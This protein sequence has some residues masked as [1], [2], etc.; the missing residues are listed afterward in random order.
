M[1]DKSFINLLTEENLSKINIDPRLVDSF[2]RVMKNHIIN[3][4]NNKVAILAEKKLI[5]SFILFLFLLSNT[6][7]L[8]VIYANKTAKIHDIIIANC[9][10]T[11]FFA[12]KIVKSKAYFVPILTM[13]VNTP[14]IK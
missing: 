4:S 7:F 1:E 8:F 2:K 5:N 12:S 10:S 13:V 14:K 9:S 11:A 3:I 6:N